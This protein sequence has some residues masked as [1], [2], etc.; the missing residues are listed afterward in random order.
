MLAG[1]LGGRKRGMSRFFRIGAILAVVSLVSIRQHFS[2]CAPDLSFSL[3]R[4]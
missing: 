3:F 2:T 4:R 1:R